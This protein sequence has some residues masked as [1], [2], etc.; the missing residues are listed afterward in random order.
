MKLKFVFYVQA[1]LAVS[2]GLGF[3]LAPAAMWSLWGAPSTDAVMNLAG[4]NT[5]VLTLLVGMVAFL[6][7]RIDNSPLRRDICLS[8]FI[9]HV[10]GFVVHVRPLLT[11]GFAF[12]PAWI[13]SLIL[14]LA[15]GYFRFLKPNA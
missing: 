1:V 3:V 9:L 10:V 4:Q 8:Y 5:G 13:F 11:G 6:A 12:G 15:F 7:A 2:S 14:A